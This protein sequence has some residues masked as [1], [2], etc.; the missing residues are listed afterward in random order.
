MKQSKLIS[1]SA[2]NYRLIYIDVM[3]VEYPE[4]MEV[5]KPYLIKE[6]LSELDIIKLNELIVCKQENNSKSENQ[7]FRSYSRQTIIN[8]LDFQKKNR[9]NNSQ[10]ARHF[11]L[12]R[13]TVAKWKKMFF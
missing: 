7:K 9:L 11:K 13:N 1:S 5:C 8:I 12:S 10:L 2:P 6:Q 4:K 3:S